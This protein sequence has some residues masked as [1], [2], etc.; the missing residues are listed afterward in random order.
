MWDSSEQSNDLRHQLWLIYSGLR[1]AE[2]DPI[3]RLEIL[4]RSRDELGKVL[5]EL[6]RLSGVCPA[7][8]KQ[9]PN[10]VGI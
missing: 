6:N 8:I 10:G 4:K 5:N 9:Q 2:Q 1:D 3:K 7:S